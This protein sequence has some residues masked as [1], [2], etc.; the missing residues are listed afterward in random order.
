MRVA[1]VVVLTITV[2]GGCGHPS[3]AADSSTPAAGASME[4]DFEGLP[5]GPGREA[6]YFTC[7]ACHSLKQFTQQRMDREEWDQVISRMVHDNKMAAPRPWARTLMLAY[8]S[9]HFGVDVEDWAGLPPG[10]GREDV[11]Y[12]CQACH[13]LKTVLQQRLSRE[14]WD[15][16]LVWMVEEQGMPEPEPAE[17]ARLLD[18]L[19][20]YLSPET[21]R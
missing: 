21:P 13:S 8:L 3:P 14:D 9:S 10:V 12:L 2:F 15:E 11:F 18:Y 5:P 1:V 7:T 20:A 17:Y 6:V 4:E 19:G 16:T